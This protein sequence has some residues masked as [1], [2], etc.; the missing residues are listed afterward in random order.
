MADNP[1]VLDFINKLY[2]QQ[3]QSGTDAIGRAFA[4]IR[5]RTISEQGATGRLGSPVANYNIGEVD[6][7]QGNAIS[8]FIAKLTGQKAGAAL[9]YQGLQDRLG[10]E[11]ERLTSE[12]NNRAMEN[13]WRQLMRSDQQHGNGWLDSLDDANKVIGF[14]KNVN[15]LGSDIKGTMTDLPRGFSLGAS[16]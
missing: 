1:A 4:P 3:G 8:D 2:D 14:G 12:N 13:A 15:S 9:D 5:S 6:T 16:L 7:K 11:R 10:F